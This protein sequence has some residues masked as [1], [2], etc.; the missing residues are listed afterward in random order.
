MSASN[1]IYHPEIN[2]SAALVHENNRAQARLLE[3]LVRPQIGT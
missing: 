3:R 1:D 2:I